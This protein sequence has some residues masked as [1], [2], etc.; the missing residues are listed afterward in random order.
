MAELEA[1]IS[2][3]ASDLIRETKKASNAWSSFTKGLAKDGSAVS[4]SVGDVSK[5]AGD[6]TTSL[7]KTAKAVLGL[8]FKKTKKGF[9]DIAK[10]ATA[11][12]LGLFRLGKSLAS[13][14]F[15]V[16]TAGAKLALSAVKGLA[17][18]VGALSVVLAGIGTKA[19]IEFGKFQSA[20]AQVRTLVDE[21]QTDIASLETGVRDLAV[22]FGVN[23]KE[24]TVAAY[25]AISAGVEPAKVIG[26]L[27]TAFEGAA[28][29]AAT[30]EET[31]NLVTSALNAYNKPVE[32][33][34]RVSDIFF[35]RSRRARR[36]RRSSRPRSA[37]S[38]RSLP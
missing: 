5:S 29:G 24:S 22:A 4:R 17:V 11:A 3:D 31:V 9:K 2:A 26:F 8:N 7:Q 28:A 37:R 14:G 20:F 1:K 21:S 27:T 13:I 35:A 38:L 12:S 30:V 34:G 19:V 32:E 10:N 18:G 25:Q 33:A 36:R 23:L 6:L 15:S 16:L